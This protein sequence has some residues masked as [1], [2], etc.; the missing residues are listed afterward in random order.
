MTTVIYIIYPLWGTSGIQL[1]LKDMF[2]FIQALLISPTPT[3]KFIGVYFTEELKYAKSISYRVYLLYGYLF[4][5][6]E[7]PFQG[8]VTNI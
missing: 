4:K 3:G 2:G 7:T 1:L 8:F 5:R 6:M